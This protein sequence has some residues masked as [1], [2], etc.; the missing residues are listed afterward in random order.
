MLGLTARQKELVD[1]IAAYTRRTGGVAPSYA[2]M[3]QALGVR[4]KNRIHDLLKKC[5]ERGAVTR[6]PARARSVALADQKHKEVWFRYDRETE[7]FRPLHSGT[8]TEPSP[9]NAQR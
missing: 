3:M 5:E 6:L 7:S 4:S 8:V 9:A 1:F 2:E